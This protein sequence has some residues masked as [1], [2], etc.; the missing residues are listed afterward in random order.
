[1]KTL[2]LPLCLVLAGCAT[3]EDGRPIDFAAVRTVEPGMTQ[4]QVVAILGEPNH[5]QMRADGSDAWVWTHATPLRTD[6]ASFIFYRGRV[7]SVPGDLITS[8]QELAAHKLTAEVQQRELDQEIAF[9]DAAIEQSEREKVLALSD[10]AALRTAEVAA[11]AP[12]PQPAA[13]LPRATRDYIAPAGNLW[14]GTRLYLRDTRQFIGSIQA[15]EPHKFDNGL[16]TTG[17]LINFADGGRPLWV[18]RSTAK[19]LYLIRRSEIP[20]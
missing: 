6:T 11:S 8:K 3:F 19:H 16:E 7:I 2:L 4:D 1:M 20:Q 15:I 12:A 18:P 9:A 17:V 5:K 14:I 10:A 13:N